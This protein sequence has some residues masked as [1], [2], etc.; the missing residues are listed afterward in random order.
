MISE[1]KTNKQ[2]PWPLVRERT[3]P[4]VRPPLVDEWFPK[5]LQ[6]FKSLYFQKCLLQTVRDTNKNR[7]D[8][9]TEICSCLNLSP[10]SFRNIL[11]FSR[12]FSVPSV[13]R[14]LFC[15]FTFNLIQFLP[16]SFFSYSNFV[17]ASALICIYITFILHCFFPIRTCIKS[18]GTFIILFPFLLKLCH[19]QAL[20]WRHRQCE[21]VALLSTHTGS[22]NYFKL[23]GHQLEYLTCHAQLLFI[24]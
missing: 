1:K 4:T 9:I 23:L 14:R 21:A 18:F 16:H 2:T 22:Y 15:A 7:L 6:N 11:S 17:F 13:L 10:S 5:R 3:I 20:W 8:N 12:F 24:N 19:H